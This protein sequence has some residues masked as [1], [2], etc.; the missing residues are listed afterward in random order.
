MFVDPVRYWIKYEDYEFGDPDNL[1]DPI[2]YEELD[3]PMILPDGRI[4]NLSTLEM[5]R[6]G[7]SII[8]PFTRQRFSWWEKCR[9]T[10]AI[11]NGK[12]VDFIPKN[13]SIIIKR[14]H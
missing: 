6:E 9:A 11:Y 10:I 14:L 4:Y 2:T 1:I 5:M 12:M 8:S 7:N 3:M 13:Y